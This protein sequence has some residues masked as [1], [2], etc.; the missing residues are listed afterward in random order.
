MILIAVVIIGVLFFLWILFPVSP[1]DS[2]EL[3]FEREY[4]GIMRKGILR[5]LMSSTEEPM[6]I[7][8]YSSQIGLVKFTEFH[9]REFREIRVKFNSNIHIQNALDVNLIELESNS[10]SSS[11]FFTT[12]NGGYLLKSLQNSELA[13]LKRFLD[14]YYR[15]IHHS[16]WSLLPRF[17]GLY[18]LEI[19]NS[20]DHLIENLPD[21]L[22]LV[23]MQ[24]WFPIPRLIKFDIKGCTA[25]R[26][27][28][29]S[30]DEL[31]ELYRD[32]DRHSN[33]TKMLQ[34]FKDMD[35]IILKEHGLLKLDFDKANDFA[36]KL[37][38]DIG[39]L[40]MHDFMDY[41]LLIG[42]YTVKDTE[43]VLYDEQLQ[44]TWFYS[45]DRKTVND[46][47]QRYNANK[48]LEKGLKRSNSKLNSIINNM[49]SDTDYSVA[50]PKEY[51]E[52][53]IKFVNRNIIS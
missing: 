44:S 40:A 16:D 26:S 31:L 14:T 32:V 21:S 6:S 30:V 11:K 8:F 3:S 2:D 37:S 19:F 23:L 28:V 17:Y 29:N 12:A 50:E 24:N 27:A 13:N 18:S 43:I 5:S 51:A 47:L 10:H 42:I 48:K 41:S 49:R 25:G 33:P 53:L 9:S 38:K 52:R 22:Q 45:N 4:L 39:L 1:S 36:D 7:S 35:F 15:Y 20:E 46:I 34:P